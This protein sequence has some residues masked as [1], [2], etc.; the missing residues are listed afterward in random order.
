MTAA[1]QRAA[2]VR[3][4]RTPRPARDEVPAPPP[5][6]REKWVDEGP[7]R[8][9]AVEATERA[10]TPMPAMPT[11]QRKPGRL[12]PDVSAT[13]QREAGAQRS[14]RY[15]ERLTSAAEALAR[16]RFD[17]ARRMVAPVL[18]DLPGIALAHEIAGQAFYAMGQW[19]KAISELELARQLDGSLVHHPVLADC[20]RALKRY[21]KVDHLWQE[22]KEASPE[23][24]LMAEGRII[25][26]GALADQGDLRGALALMQKAAD[27]PRGKVREHHLRQWYVLGDLHDRAGDVIDARR[28]FAR[29]ADVDRDFAD[30]RQRLA[31][32]GR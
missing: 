16:N 5:W 4:T 22:L 15:E 12:D 1:E 19:R 13:V 17:D 23:P 31:N 18:R 11:R 2:Q 30:V 21:D 25:A 8:A 29:V 32:L 24:A 26:A 28:F 3:A 27:P 6:E 9:A 14:A 20:Y 10:S 7:L